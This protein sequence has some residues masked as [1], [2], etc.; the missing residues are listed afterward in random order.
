MNHNEKL[1]TLHDEQ[2]GSRKERNCPECVLKK[3]LATDVMRK[4]HKAGF[5]FANDAIQCHDQI[6]H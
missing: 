4:Q 1:G 5:R 3:V 6:V 2:E